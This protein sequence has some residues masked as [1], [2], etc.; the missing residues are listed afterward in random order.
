MYM[1][2]QSLNMGMPGRGLRFNRKFHA[3]DWY[4]TQI[5]GP[6]LSII[7]QQQAAFDPITCKAKYMASIHAHNQI[8]WMRPLTEGPEPVQSPL[9]PL[10]LI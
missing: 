4:S 3:E 5:F 2:S 6:L 8:L 10:Q 9:L 1:L 7:F